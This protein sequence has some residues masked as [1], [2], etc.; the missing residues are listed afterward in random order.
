MVALELR[1]K[2][3][4]LAEQATTSGPG[5]AAD[6]QPEGSPLHRAVARETGALHE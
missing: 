1:Q 6:A 4:E 5:G 2:I 3:L